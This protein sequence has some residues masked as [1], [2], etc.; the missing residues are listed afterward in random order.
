MFDSLNKK[1][2]IIAGSSIVGLLVLIILISF[3]VSTL[4]PSYVSYV[5][6][7]ERLANAAKS[8]YKANPSSLPTTDGET[9]VYYS[10]LEEG[11]YI[12]PITELLENGANCTAEV[13]VNKYGV[14]YNY[15]PYLVCP[16][17]YES[18]ELYKAILEDNKIVTEGKGLYRGND[19]YYFRGEEI[20]NYVMIDDILWR[21]V[22]IN[23]DNSITI[24]QTKP[25]DDYYE[26]D[27]RYNPEEDD[28]TGINDFEVSRLKIKL[29]ELAGGV[30][31][32]SDT[33]KA[34]LTARNLCVGKRELEETDSS[35]S[36]ECSTM[37]EDTYLL[38]L[39]TASEYMAAS[40]DENC[41]KTLSKS[42]INYNFLATYY[43]SSWSLTAMADNTKG[44]FRYSRN[45]ILK[46]DASVSSSLN[47]TAFI[48]KRAF[49][50]SGTGTLTDP[51]IMK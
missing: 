33:T 22:K 15:V 17:D 23:N 21:I 11:G 41:I 35:G 45:G 3:I 31:V 7:E 46:S 43:S 30:E 13:I 5:K 48:S 47:L 6:F 51:Y 2:L 28:K 24:I 20:N 9:I 50:K 42:C 19:S 1:T 8:Y 49:Y 4:S 16:G 32:L 26:W 29:Q 37:S 34:R 44:A 10:T 25:L 38:G 18:K 36:I 12:K 14:N 40:L 39:I 27:N